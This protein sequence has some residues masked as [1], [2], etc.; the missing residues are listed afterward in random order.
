MVLFNHG[1]AAFEVKQG[2]RIAQF[3]CEKIVYPELVEVEDLDQ[4]ERG[5][6]GFGSTGT[7]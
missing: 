2:D 5:E 7:N 3:I 6:G 4:T 1:D